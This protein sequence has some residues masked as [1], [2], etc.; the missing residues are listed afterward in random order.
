MLKRRWIIIDD[1]MIGIANSMKQNSYY[2]HFR[3]NGLKRM[4]ALF[5]VKKFLPVR[6]DDEPII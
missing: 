1:Q 4:G 2:T 6:Y 3:K 5:N